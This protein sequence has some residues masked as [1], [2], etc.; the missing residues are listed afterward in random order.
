MARND[1]LPRWLSAVHPRFH[2]PHRAEIVLAVIVSMLILVTDVRGAIGFSSFGVL[3]YYFISNLAAYRQTTENRRYPRFLQIVGAIGC[4]ALVV[5]LPWP[6]IV[7]G[8]VVLAIGLAYR[9]V[10]LRGRAR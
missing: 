6:S 1:D 10:R 7:G 5:T 9:A 2:V 8:V 3:L 4:L